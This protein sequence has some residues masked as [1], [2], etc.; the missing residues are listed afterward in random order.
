MRGVYEYIQRIELCWRNLTSVCLLLSNLSR[1][2]LG[3]SIRERVVP[4]Y[5]LASNKT[6]RHTQTARAYLLNM[7]PL[8]PPE[9]PS[10]DESELLEA[11]PRRLLNKPPEL[12]PSA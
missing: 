8:L 5:K 7:N 11:L 2:E 1:F 12:L 6:S 3:F 4:A 10:T 9:V